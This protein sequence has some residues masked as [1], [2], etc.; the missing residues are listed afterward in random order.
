MNSDFSNPAGKASAVVISTAYFPPVSYFIAIANS[1]NVFLESCE[2]YQKQTYRNRCRIFAC[3][4][5]L[6]LSV[7]IVKGDSDRIT[8]VKVD[9]ST[10]W[11]QQH[12]R[13]IVSAYRSSPFFEYYQDEIF[14]ILDSREESLFTLNERLIVKLI[15]LLGIRRELKHTLDFVASYGDDVMDLRNAIHPKK[16]IPPSVAALRPYYQVFS[17]KYGFLPNLSVIDL[18]FNEGPNAIDYI[19]QFRVR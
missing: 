5:A 13:A 10:T 4:G 18:L 11:L 3:D 2:S 17:D 15:F 7:P 12:K 16:E 14:P 6:P 8:S 9:Y 1:E 19:T